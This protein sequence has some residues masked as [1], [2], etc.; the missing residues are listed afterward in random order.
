MTAQNLNTVEGAPPLPLYKSHKKVRAAK[1]KEVYTAGPQNGETVISFE[2]ESLEKHIYQKSELAN[3]PEP[4]AGMYLVQYEDGYV[5]FSPAEPFE[6]GYTPAD[7]NEDDERGD[8]VADEAEQQTGSGGQTADSVHDIGW[9]VRQLHD[10][11]IVR[12]SGWNGKGM[13]LLFVPGS[14]FEV[15]RPPLLGVFP[16]GTRVKYHAHIDMKT[17]QGDIVPWLASQTDLQADDWE[18]AS[19]DDKPSGADLDAV[20]QERRQA[21]A[22][23]PVQ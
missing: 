19:E 12:R 7:E 11:Q 16:E 10:G 17:A 15:N 8:V 1:I 6:A 5:S 23:A 18:L 9:A 21:Q 3:R 13:F 2:D 20:D 4:K 14:E 22:P